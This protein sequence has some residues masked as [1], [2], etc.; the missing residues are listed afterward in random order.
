MHDNLPQ[1]HDPGA[2]P[3]APADYPPMSPY[4]D[5]PEGGQINIRRLLA[6]VL[7]NKWLVLAVTAIGT[8]AGLLYVRTLPS[9]YIA[10]TTVWVETSNRGGDGPIQPRELL[11]GGAW[12]ELLRSYEVLD[13]VVMQE[14]LFLEIADPSAAPAFAEFELDSEFRPGSYRLELN[15]RTGQYRLHRESEG[16]VDSGTIG[17]AIG[18]PVGFR[19][20]PT[21]ADLG[22][23]NRIDFTVRM[24]RD[25][26]NEVRNTMSAR[27]D[28]SGNFMR[29]DM[30]GTSPTRVAS[31]L[32]ALT[33]RFVSVAGELKGAHLH[34]LT[35]ILEGQL[36]YAQRNLE[37]AEQELEGFRVATITLP[38]DQAA[39][40][41][42]GL[43]MTRDP[44]FGSFFQ[45]RLEQEQVRRDRQAI[46]SA[47]A[48]GRVSV[49]ALEVVPSVRTSSQL[50]AVLGELA[51]ARA[52]LRTLSFRYTPEHAAVQEVAERVSRLEGDVVPGLARGLAN[53]LAARDRAI[54][55][56]IGQ[57]SR[58]M[59]Q[60]PPRAIEEARLRRQVTVSENLYTTLQRRFEE[61]RLASASTVPDVRILDRA[62]PP[63]SPVNDE[64]SRILLMAIMGSLGLGILGAIVRD[65]F[66][67]TIRYAD[68]VSD[69]MGLSV[70]GAIPELSA[71]K[72]PAGRNGTAEA[73]EAFRGIRMNVLYAYGAAGPVTLAIS[74]P[75]PGDGKSF[76]ASN[77]ALSFADLGK[78]VL[79][80]DGDVR[81]GGLH[82]IMERPRSPGLT[83]FL[84]GDLP[85]DQV[86]QRT[87]YTNLSFISTG[88]LKVTAPE[89]ISSPQMR[90]LLADLRSAYDVIIV[91]T[92]P[93]GA[94]VDPFIF[95]TLTGN[96]LLVLRTGTTNKELA[97]AKLGL[98]ERLPIRILG[99]VVNGLKDSDRNYY[100]RYY[101]YLPGYEPTDEE[102]PA[103]PQLPKV[104]S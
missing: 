12:L 86:V 73:L 38:S 23:Q 29:I 33:E 25:A 21:P 43:E 77:L 52:E 42:A 97:E 34:E 54:Q 81:R 5:E 53:E 60:I 63:Q 16:T 44:V 100:H 41:A 27:I 10:Q 14:R 85:R 83:D 15:R 99:S 40:M 84:A 36:D 70:L 3:S 55:G 104:P 4:D 45:L 79:L 2:L 87:R 92:A 1:R 61:T 95:S 75:G 88:R 30:R 90:D 19:W 80:V 68:Q 7:R 71:G 65:R 8:V 6:A 82:R 31:V 89:L 39:P 37:Q 56:Q 59:E 13:A 35:N 69:D 57:A 101:S 91:D 76:V 11:T 17:A 78:K 94:G 74:S 46:Q 66:D 28:R 50:L 96:L 67:H 102:D 93:L 18:H 48:G 32:N 26:A 20:Q 51:S 49:E 62:S 9:E 24:P 22:D 98:V 58:E 103:V 64:K 72:Q 47:I